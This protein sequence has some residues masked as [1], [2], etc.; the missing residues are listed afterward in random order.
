MV[1]DLFEPEERRAV[2]DALFRQGVS[3]VSKEY[4]LGNRVSS[5]TSNWISHVT[6]GGILSA[7]A[8]ETESEYSAEQLEPHLTGM[9]LKLGELVNDTFDED[10][11]YGEGYSYANFTMQTLGETLP[12]LER[13]F[14]VRFLEK[15]GRAHRFLL[16]QMD[17]ETSRIYDF[18]DTNDHFFGGLPSFTNFAY[19]LGKWRDPYLKWLYDRSPGRTDRDL[20]FADLDVEAR[21]PDD[22]PPS[23]LFRDVGTAIFRSGFA[24]EDFIFVFR[25]GPFFNHQ[26]F[27]QG[28]FFIAD[29]GEAL[30]VEVGKTDYYQDHWYQPLAIQA[31][32]HNTVLFDHNPASQTAGDFA[33]DVA[34]WR[35]R[36]SI[37]DF[38]TW[39][40]GGFVSARLEGVY[41]DAVESLRRSALWLAP[42]T[43]LLIDR[44]RGVR[45]AET[46]Q[47]RF[48]APRREDIQVRGKR[49][50][51]VRPKTTLI[52][53]A[54]APAH[55]DWRVQ[56][57]PLTLSE[58]GEED[59]LSMKARGFL[60]RSLAVDHGVVTS[61]HLLST[62]RELVENSKAEQAPDHIAWSLEGTRYLVNTSS[63]GT[64]SEDGV[65]T[66]AIVYADTPSG[67]IV[68]H[69]TK[70]ELSGTMELIADAP[71]SLVLVDAGFVFSSSQPTRLTIHRDHEPRE[72]LV[73]GN[74]VRDWT[75]GSA[76]EL[77]IMLPEGNG[78]V[79]LR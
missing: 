32:G 11:N 58:F 15:I 34:A 7:L 28:S 13:V 43:I 49:G 20:F 73:Q 77:T 30:V 53:D 17:M 76:G 37:T 66:D 46:I 72:V 52:V 8:I 35:D 68:L 78:R 6:G 57:R 26:H 22:L 56:K 1:Y 79:E 38:L 54:L 36:A 4:V 70:L 59:P 48:H 44:V 62:D 47:L 60:E 12:A 41:G 50:D 2:A 16:Y 14:G 19:A 65:V 31:G 33:K 5:N 74:V 40:G 29:R 71:L 67:R 55:G 64:I 69:A 42:R 25:A 45:S 24:P 23:V 39:G 3:A 75:Y 18:G 51:I 63:N 27:D 21:P 61:V 9:I 10:G